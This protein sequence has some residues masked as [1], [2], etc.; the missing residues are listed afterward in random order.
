M[1]IDELTL[2]KRKYLTVKYSVVMAFRD[3]ASPRPRS[4]YGWV[5]VWVRFVSNN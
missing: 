1:D 4:K 3:D 2:K 5:P